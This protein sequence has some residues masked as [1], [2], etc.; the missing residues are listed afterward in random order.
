M[1]RDRRTEPAKRFAVNLN[2]LRY[3]AGESTIIKDVGIKVRELG[4]GLGLG[5]GF[6]I[7]TLAL[8][9]S[10]TLSRTLP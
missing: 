6:K 1:T 10:L 2:I 7:R 4:F 8:A 5:L 3:V 9:L